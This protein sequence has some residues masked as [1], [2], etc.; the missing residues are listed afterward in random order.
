MTDRFKLFFALARLCFLLFKASFTKT[1]S[2]QI[3]CFN[4]LCLISFCFT[5][6]VQSFNVNASTGSL[7]EDFEN[8]TE[9]EKVTHK[10]SQNK[11]TKF[12]LCETIFYLNSV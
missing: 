11:Q 2:E 1:T 9:R 12:F 7:T 8:R 5:V 3:E 4:E 6:Y 10:M